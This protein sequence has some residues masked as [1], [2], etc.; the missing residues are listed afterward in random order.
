MVSS[1]HDLAGT[2]FVDTADA[3]AV[4]AFD[5]ARRCAGGATLW[6]VWLLPIV[7]AAQLTNLR[8]IAE[9]GLTTGGNPFTAS[10]SVQS[11]AARTIRVG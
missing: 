8:S 11:N 5:L 6:R 1:A 7:I 10:R 3:L 9:H 2:G 4:A